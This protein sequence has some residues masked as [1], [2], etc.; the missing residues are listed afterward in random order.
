MKKSKPRNGLMK[1]RSS[2]LTS[3]VLVALVWASVL[4]F[5]LKSFVKKATKKQQFNQA[6]EDRARVCSMLP[7][8]QVVWRLSSRLFLVSIPRHLAWPVLD[9]VQWTRTTQHLD[10]ATWAPV[11]CLIFCAV[12]T[13]LGLLCDRGQR[14]GRGV[15][16]D[17]AGPAKKPLGLQL[18]L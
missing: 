9:I 2:S 14:P 3:E 1:S 18:Q 8:M 5:H 10:P 6:P 15:S 16:D 12:K 7:F 13:F 17:W 11:T 4:K